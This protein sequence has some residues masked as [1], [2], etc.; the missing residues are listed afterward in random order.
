MTFYVYKFFFN[1]CFTRFIKF[2]FLLKSQL[3]IQNIS[4]LF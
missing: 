1:A 4:K 3:I 2:Q